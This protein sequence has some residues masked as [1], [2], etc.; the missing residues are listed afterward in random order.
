MVSF[1]ISLH[2]KDKAILDLIQ[3]KLAIGKIYTAG[4][5]AV[6]LEIRSI[7]ELLV[8]KAHFDKYPLIS[9][10]Q[11]D[12]ELF[13][14]ALDYIQ[15][16]LHLN[17]EGLIKILSIKASMNRGL[18]DGLKYAFPDIIPVARPLVKNHI[19]PDPQ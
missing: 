11:S 16:G 4:P 15:Q 10:K 3:D 19:I 13:K 9:Q 14:L 12:Y 1:Q 18:A 7:K 2:T 8:L 6:T 5:T 17:T